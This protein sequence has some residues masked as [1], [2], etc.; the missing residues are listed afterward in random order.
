MKLSVP[1]LIDLFKKQK[2]NTRFRQ[3]LLLYGVNILGIPLGIVTSIV[4][5]RFLGPKMFGDYKF[6][7]SLFNLSMIIFSFGFFQA[8]NRAL[9]LN[10]DEQKSKELYGAELVITFGL[11]AI[12]SIGL[13]GYGIL[14]PNLKEKGLA[15]F[16][17]YLIP[18]SWIFLLVRYFEVLLQA[19]N[20]I[21]LLASTRFWP[22]FGFFISI[23]IVFYVFF[24][25][26]GNKLGLIWFFYLLTQAIVFISIIFLIKPSINNLKKRIG[27]IWHYNRI[28]GIQVYIGSLIAVGFAQITA[29]LISYFGNDNAGVGY[30]SLAL[31]IAAPLSLIPNVI[32]TTHYKDFASQTHVPRRLLLVTIGLSFAAI[33]LI[34]II[35]GPFIRIF[36]GSDF[37]PVVNLTYILSIGIALHGLADFYNRFLGAHGQGKAL[38]NSSFFVG[39][40]L[41]IFSFFLVPLFGETGAVITKAITGMIYIMIIYIYYYILVKKLKS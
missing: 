18:F 19:D 6:L 20:R 7:L 2:N 12:L 1:L 14:D 5:T 25:F 9:V 34:W 16:F 4:I 27:E 38:R 36:Y 10:N 15:T 28:F 8:G 30:Y 31:T 3:V 13:L 33:V 37:E 29:I 39:F 23:L 35:V 26:E 40:S 17:L 24:E 21:E 41:L 11:F 32:A 22:K